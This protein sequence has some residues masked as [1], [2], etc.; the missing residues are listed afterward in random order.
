MSLPAGTYGIAEA[1]WLDAG[2]EIGRLKT[3]GNILSA[4]N[5]TTQTTAFNAF[6]AAVQ[7]VVLGE[8]TRQLYGNETLYAVTQPANG[9]A[10]EIKLFV[11]CQDDTNGQKFNFSIPTLDPT[12]PEYVQNVNARD[13]IV[14][15]SPTAIATLVTAIEG[16][17]INPQTGNAAV[18][19]GMKVV[20]RST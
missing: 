11:Q 2:N 18:V 8:R 17:V 19:I 5:F 10:R 4:A 6:I 20:G 15:D 1:S 12:I 9:A 14:I 16:F 13:V 7:A 3:Y